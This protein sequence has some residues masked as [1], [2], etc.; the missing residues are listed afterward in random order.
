MSQTL[1]LVGTFTMVAMLYASVGLGGGSSYTALLAVTGFTATH[2]PPVALSLN[3]VVA[4][5]A[6][7]V[8]TREGHLRWDRTLPLVL[9]SVPASFA[10]A[11]IS[12]E[13]P[14]VLGLLGGVLLL[15]AIVLWTRGSIR[16]NFPTVSVPFYPWAIPTGIVLGLLAGMTGI[17]GGIFL[18]PMILLFAWTGEKE[19]A[20]VASVFVWFNSL[21]GLSAHAMR[22]N[23]PT[24]EIVPLVLAVGVGG[25]VGGWF[26]ARVASRRTVRRIIASLLLVVSVK[27][28]WGVT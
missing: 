19:A 22:G 1:L 11:S 20:A 24:G 27:L 3:L 8:F 15:A 5:L 13:G 10:G 28:M 6:L 17:G 14:T 16:E 7:Y 9:T 12:L 18:A 25:A 23:V 26:G 2:I 21:A 4:G